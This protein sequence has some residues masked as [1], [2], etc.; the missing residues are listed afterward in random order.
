M[1]KI[2]LLALAVVSVTAFSNSDLMAQDYQNSYRF[3]VGLGYGTQFPYP[4]KGYFGN[5]RYRGFI[6]D[7]LWNAGGIVDRVDAPPYFAQYPPVYYNGI[8]SRP[9]GIS[10]YAAPPGITPVEMTIPMPVPQAIQNPYYEQ[11]LT[12]ASENKTETVAPVG[13]QSTHIYNPYVE[14]ISSVN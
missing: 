2:L 4:N 1:K 10:P 14:T 12:P 6:G 5:R 9:Y 7:G 13:N 3:G 11:Q 8:I